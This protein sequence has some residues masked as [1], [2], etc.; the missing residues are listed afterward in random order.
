MPGRRLARLLAGETCVAT[1]AD[2]WRHQRSRR[3]SGAAVRRKRRH[4]AGYPRLLRR[5][6]RSGGVGAA[7]RA[8]H[9]EGSP[10]PLVK[11]G[12]VIYPA[13]SEERTMKRMRR[14]MLPR[15]TP[16][17]DMLELLGDRP[18]ALC[19]E[20]IRFHEETTWHHLN[21][22]A[23]R[24]TGRRSHGGNTCWWWRE[25]PDRKPQP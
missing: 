1:D 13:G 23:W 16:L 5:R 3:G 25:P 18:V 8:F 12:G 22:G 6:V 21:A 19:R 24:R 9:L 4:G 15:P 17:A 2:P 7:Y 10:S 20:L 11:M 14:P